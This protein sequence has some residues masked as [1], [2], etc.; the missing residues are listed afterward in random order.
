M[1]NETCGTNTA[2][3]YQLKLISTRL[4]VFTGSS[5]TN[6]RETVIFI[7]IP[8]HFCRETLK[9]GI[10]LLLHW[11]YWTIFFA[12]IAEHGCG[13]MSESL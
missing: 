9:S 6:E 12:F 11:K 7:V 13:N 10:Y 5:C 1:E 2:I 8:I 3:Q 4:C